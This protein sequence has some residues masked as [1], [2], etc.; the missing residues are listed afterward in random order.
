MIKATKACYRDPIYKQLSEGE[1]VVVKCD[2]EAFL[3]HD[4][5]KENQTVEIQMSR[6][7]IN[8]QKYEV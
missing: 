2:L 5:D 7:G 3:P 6:R 4:D 8:W 1:R